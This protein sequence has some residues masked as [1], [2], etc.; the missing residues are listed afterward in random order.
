MQ[1]RECQIFH[2]RFFLIAA[3]CGLFLVFPAC[4]SQSKQRHLLRGEEYLQKRKFH[5]AAM[6]FRSAAEI[7][8]NSAEAYWGLARAH[9]NLG[10]F[11][12]AVD[13]LRKTTEF[14]PGNL[15]AKA[16]L[17]NYFLAFSPPLFAETEKLLEQIFALDANFIEGHILKASLLSTQ[18]K[19]EAEVL[20]VLNHAISLNLKRTE[21]YLSLSRYFMKQK[22]TGEAEK[23]IQQGISLGENK[24]LGYLEYGRFF[25]FTKKFPE[26]ET[27]FQK[28]I[29]AEPT[30]MEAREAIAEFHVAQRQYEKA[31]R[32][33]REL[34]QIQENSPESRMQLAGFYSQ[35]GQE[36]NAIQVLS[37][38]LTDAPE[39]AR[40]RY[41]LAEIYLNRKEYEKVR[42]EVEQLLS[43]NN[44]DAEA[45]MLRARV[46]LQENKPENAVKDLEDVLKKQPSQKNA[47]F[48]MTQARLA[49]G[50]FDQARAF[51]GDLEKY[52]PTF[53]R[54]K[55]LKIQ[56]SF[57]AGEP[58]TA[59]RQSNELLEAVKNNYPNAETTAQ[60]LEDLRVRAITS[61]GLANLELGRIADAKTDLAEV[62]RLSPN[63]SAA[64]VNLAKVSVVEGNLAEAQNLY[65]KAL[66]AEAQNFDALSGLIS[67]L[68]RQ[69]NFDAAHQRIDG[70]IQQNQ[71]DTLAALHYLKAD[72]FTAQKD[73]ASAEAALKKAMEADENYL[74]AYS[75]YA[76]LLVNQNQTGKAIEQYLKIVE[77]KPSASVF[78]LLG[79][80]EE[81][82]NDFAKA[83][84]YYRRALEVAPETPIAANNL[85]WLIAENNQGN[86]D[87]ALRLAQT[88]VN[89]YPQTASFYDTL[90]FVYFK[91]GLY[92]PAVEHL[93]K[94]VAFD[95]TE[96]KRNGR[97]V[98]PGFRVRLGMALASAGD[99]PS[100]KREAATALERERDLS[101]KEAQEAK[102]LLATL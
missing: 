72:V 30:S 101:Q 97:S 26:A 66:T 50:Q 83:E 48:Y 57:A 13:A 9:E 35:I 58:E 16:K 90:G 23:A 36:D 70:M 38:I 14:A 99:K 17:G 34:V 1:T 54:V 18:G 20:A 62:A 2:F 73:I 44:N 25:S 7:D 98:N 19:P 93:K 68:T 86:L 76:A 59:L 12:E 89:R 81:T 51:I 42:G 79:M 45:L 84:N 71:A 47:L 53:L 49:L 21:S 4:S 32:A 85:A 100:A 67:V 5:E 15:D 39:M 33:Y 22:N 61:R 82:R 87:E 60:S 40:A 63:S 92:S 6:E 69:G 37:G 102:N 46:Y 65:E 27:Q 52:H 31:E 78:T 28:A 43:V 95:E 55:L 74:P 24:M 77:K 64:M 56:A 3:L 88:A 41:R 8:K 91:K 75:A 11:N 10:Q 29:E 94:A 80:L 96:A